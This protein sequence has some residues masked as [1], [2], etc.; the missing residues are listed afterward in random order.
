VPDVSA[1]ASF[2]NGYKIVVNGKEVVQG[3]TSA[4]APLW[5]ALIALIGAEA[6]APLGRLHPMLY[7]DEAL[8]RR[9]SSGNNKYGPLGYEARDGWNACCGLG[10]PVG[11]AFFAKFA[12]TS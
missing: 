5:V 7:G 11:R 9:V 1:A 2:T 4:V 6:A 10:A 12:A 8:F 3:G